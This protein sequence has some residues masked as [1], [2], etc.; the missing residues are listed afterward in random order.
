MVLRSI[1]KKYNL[2]KSGFMSKEAISTAIL[3]EKGGLDIPAKKVKDVLAG[4]VPRT[5]KK[6]NR[7][8]MPR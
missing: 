4:L 2:D 3:S 8:L 6:V 5:D 1:F 7:M